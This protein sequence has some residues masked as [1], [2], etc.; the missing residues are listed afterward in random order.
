ME[1]NKAPAP[2][3]PKIPQNAPLNQ[4]DNAGAEEKIKKDS[5]EAPLTQRGLKRFLKDT[6]KDFKEPARNASHSD[7]GGDKRD[8]F[9]QEAIDDINF[10]RKNRIVKI[11]TFVTV[12]VL[13]M[14]GVIGL[15]FY[16]SKNASK[17]T[18]GQNNGTITPK[19]I[20]F[21]IV[22]SSESVGNASSVL[23]TLGNLQIHSSEKGWVSV[24]QE[25]KEYDLLLLKKEGIISLI[26]SKTEV[27]PGT[28]D[29]VKL[30]LSKI[31][32]VENGI[33]KEA[34]IPSKVLRIYSNVIFNASS[35][36]TVVFD[37]KNDQ[38]IHLA[39]NGKLIFLPVIRIETRSDT[40]STINSDNEIT[41]NSGHV[42]DDKSVG[43]YVNGE[44]RYN[45]VLDKGT[46]LDMVGN[47]IKI[48]RAQEAGE[49]IKTTATSAIK[50]ATSENY[51]DKAISVEL[52]TKSGKK[53][54]LVSGLK[55][56]ELKNVYIDA[57]T[58]LFVSVA[59]S[60]YE[61]CLVDVSS[62]V[63][64]FN[65]CTLDS[66][67][68]GAPILCSIESVSKIFDREFKDKIEEIKARCPLFS[69]NPCVP[70]ESSS[71]NY[72]CANNKCAVIPKPVYTTTIGNIKFALESSIDLGSVLKVQSTYQNDL[73]TTERF[74]KVTIGAQ[75]KGKTETTQF[76]WEVGNVIDSEGR[77]FISIKNKAYQFLPQPDLCGTILKPEFDLIPCVMMYEVS[78]QSAGLK[79]EVINRSQKQGKALLDLDLVY[80]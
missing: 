36:S 74:I 46:K 22:N 11:I 79:V 25:T 72:K 66:E 38:S 43:M 65:S 1:E 3:T 2:G 6:D 71:F 10:S 51:L 63:Q 78:K 41:V 14:G 47:V 9:G 7:A 40:N 73:V 35:Q 23:V 12:I 5:L 60:E 48:T 17:N 16:V 59:S 20:V 57:K 54:W 50:F 21:G 33:Q 64:E 28:Y 52:V 53:A 70:L 68:A 69:E 44:I 61:R 62:T 4:Q 27:E 29:Q 30:T 75:N 13:I 42:D 15:Y 26:T 49:S 24:W 77:T 31:V 8:S 56:L 45:F 39:G 58:G 18:T 76:A 37:I 67:C 80:L 32:V 34:I 55:N 19:G